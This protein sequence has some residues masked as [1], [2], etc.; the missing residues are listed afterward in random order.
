M[1]SLTKFTG[2]FIPIGGAEDKGMFANA[3]YPFKK[4]GV[5]AHVLRESGGKDAIIKVIPTASS[6][7]V[8]VGR[9][10]TN[11]F[12][13]LGATNIEILDIRDSKQGR[14]PG[15]LKA[16]EEADCLY[17]SGGNQSKIAHRLGKGPFLELLKHR[18]YNED[19]VMAGTSAGAMCMSENMIAGGSAS[20]ALVKGAVKLKTGL[21]M[22]PGLVIDTH[23]VRRG[24][25]GRLAEAVAANPTRL[26]IGIAEDTGLIIKPGYDVTVI[27]AGM[28]I[29]MDPSGL[30]HNSHGVLKE[31]TPV[32]I[33]DLRVHML[34]NGD[35]MQLTKNKIDV[36]PLKASFI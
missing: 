10:Y 21:G 23:F 5:L 34:A 18:M 11:A 8:E 9:D 15:V 2:T 14:D 16:V 22:L 4:E 33:T 25:F 30:T 6:L 12:T 36:L 17:F 32:S 29:V 20:E 28:V 27:G 24:R 7:P 31:G 13:E 26:G 3:K 35:K 1:N 19:L